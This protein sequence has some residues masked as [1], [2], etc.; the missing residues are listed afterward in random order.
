MTSTPERTE[1]ETLV[2]EVETL[3]G[4]SVDVE[5]TQNGKYIAMFMRF[6]TGPAPT[7]DTE[8]EALRR[9]IDWYRALP[10]DEPPDADLK[11]LTNA[12]AGE[13]T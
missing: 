12:E 4:Y 9:F 2:A 1:F 10:K 6:G 13:L 8:V 7:G 5:K 3:T 11:A